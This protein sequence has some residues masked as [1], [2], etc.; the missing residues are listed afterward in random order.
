MAT[1]LQHIRPWMQ[2]P[3]EESEARME[4]KMDEK[5]KVVHKRLLVE[6]DALIAPVEVV[7]EPTPEVHVHDV[8]LSA[9]FGNAILEPDPSRAAGKHNYSS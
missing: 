8:M 3:L 2:R 6:V 1:L 7:P 4:R 9:L 5:I